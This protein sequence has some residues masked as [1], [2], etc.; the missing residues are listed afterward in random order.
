MNIRNATYNKLGSIDCEIEHPDF[1]WIPHTA[2]ENDPE[3]LQIYARILNG[4]AGAIAAYVAPPIDLNRL[5]NEKLKELK[6]AAQGEANEL[7][8]GY[9]DFEKITWTD[10]EREARDWTADNTTPTPV[11]SVIA[12]A[13]SLSITELASRVIEKADTF[14]AT[15]AQIA[16]KRQ[17][18]EDTAWEAFNNGDAAGIAAVV[19]GA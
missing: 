17:A 1:G 8:S 4:D 14:R 11:L 18:L 5:L 2:S 6:S 10:Q 12:N 9:P 3:T 15:A 16:G 13:R 19:W 7:V